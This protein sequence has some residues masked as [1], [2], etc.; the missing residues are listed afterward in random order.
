MPDDGL[1]AGSIHSPIL[2]ADVIHHSKHHRMRIS[3]N[4]AFKHSSDGCTVVDDDH[5]IF[6]TVN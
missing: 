1:L 2:G 3:G 4:L 5:H 6:K